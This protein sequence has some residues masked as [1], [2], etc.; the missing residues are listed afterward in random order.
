MEYICRVCVLSFVVIFVCLRVFF[1]LSLFSSFFDFCEM[2]SSFSPLVSSNKNIQQFNMS[3]DWD[4]VNFY[5]QARA[6]MFATQK[7]WVGVAADIYGA[8]LHN[9][10]DI[11][12]RIELAT[13]YSTNNTS[14]F[15]QRIQQV[16]NLTKQMPMV[17]PDRV[18]ILG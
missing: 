15:A 9:V 10:T 5:E 17:D 8:D 12:Q 13:Y 16:V 11:N 14:L 1:S 2:D 3:S 4:G 6:T 7:N 18:A